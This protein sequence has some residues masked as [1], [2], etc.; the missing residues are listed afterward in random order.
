MLR[1]IKEK[2]ELHHG[3]KI[4]D[5]ALVA[6]ATLSN[7]YITDRFL[8]DKAIDLI[9]E[10]ASKIK[11]EVDSKPAELD[12]IDRKIMQL[13]MEYEVLKKENSDNSNPRLE[14]IMEDLRRYEEESSAVRSTWMLGKQKL[15]KIN[16]LKNQID[17]AKYS[18]EVAQREGNLAKA[19]ELSYGVIPNLR[20]ELDKLEKEHYES[21]FSREAVSREDIGNM[22][23]QITGIPVDRM[24]E[25]EKERLSSMESIIGKRVI[26]Q[27]KAIA[28][29]S[30]AIRRNRSGLQDE[31]RPIGSFL[32]LGPTGV[33]KT[34]LSKALGE[35]MFS[36]EKLLLRLDMSEYMEKHAV[37]KLIG[38]PPGYVGYEEG[39]TLTEAVRRR[40][41]QVILFDEIEKA[42]PD[43]F[44][45][46]LQIMD[47][48]RLTDSQ[49]RLV[50]FTNTI[51]ILTSNLGFEHI[52]RMSE[53][54]GVDTV[55][56]DVM[57]NVRNT[58]K[59]EFINRLDEIILFQ[60]LTRS[61][62]A[63]VVKIQLDRLALRLKS[64]EFMVSFAD[65][66]IDYIAE[67][68]FDP[69]YGARPLKR[70][71]QKKIENPLASEII[72]GRLPR[73]REILVDMDKDGEMIVVS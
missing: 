49:G 61:N 40:P 1:G 24:L 35:F 38:A 30:N 63:A 25:N 12:E 13:K 64:R 18:L 4:K 62:I 46:L 28:A 23:S 44:N 54:A 27:E 60:K 50:N 7:R 8:P 6:A 22:V 66:V 41:Y 31:S 57:E 59:P 53:D 70:L 11:M 14:K 19:G 26:G 10:A 67:N 37:S 48:G 72:A 51:V 42:H 58:F 68:G 47:D 21:N 52:S 73:E 3:V 32:F 20:K 39:G 2:Y 56:G 71:I 29:V 43:M 5:E 9:D 69:L 55:Y 33:G 34:E 45:I 15:T 65:N 17:D 36:D 16:Q